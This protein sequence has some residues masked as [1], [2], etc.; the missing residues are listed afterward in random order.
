MQTYDWLCYSPA[1]NGGYCVP[2]ALFA[3]G[4]NTHG[5]QLITK[6]MTVFAGAK[7][8]LE[9]HQC[10]TNHKASV[11]DVAMFISKC[12][13]QSSTVEQQLISHGEAMIRHNCAHL[14]SIIKT[15]LLCGRQGIALRGHQELGSDSLME[16]DN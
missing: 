6:A 5:G 8:T 10:T 1:E 15:V 16:N 7:R 14:Q 4:H 11:K 2:C 3:R 12:K 9:K 13:G